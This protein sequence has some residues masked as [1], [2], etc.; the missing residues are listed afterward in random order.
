MQNTKFANMLIT[1]RLRNHL[2]QEEA[3]DGM[4]SLC[5]RLNLP[6]SISISRST[7]ANYEKGTREPDFDRLKVIAQFYGVDYNE[8]LSYSESYEALQ[9]IAWPAGT[10]TRFETEFIDILRQL[11]VEKQGYIFGYAEGMLS[12]SKEQEQKK[13]EMQKL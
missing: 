3:A 11:P 8:L 6:E 4:R 9:A 5:R 7:L 10:L 1:L 2:T 13:N 12:A